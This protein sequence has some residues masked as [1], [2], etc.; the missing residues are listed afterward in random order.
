MFKNLLTKANCI[1]NIGVLKV[2]KYSPE[3]LLA[4]GIISVMSGTVLACK[5]TPKVEGIIENAKKTFDNIKYVT[6]NP[7]QYGDKYSEQD[8]KK[9]IAIVYVQTGV[10]LLKVYSKAIIATTFGIG[11]I[12]YSYKIIKGR[13]LASVAA[14]NLLDKAFTKYRNAVIDEFG[15]EKDEEFMYGKKT[16]VEKIVD[17]NGKEVGTK[18]RKVATQYSIY[19]RLF[20]E[21]N[22]SWSDNPEYNKMFLQSK[23]NYANDLLRTRGHLFLNEVYDMLGLERSSAGAVVGW[24][25]KQDET[26]DGYIDF[27]L[28]DF[29]LLHDGKNGEVRRAFINNYNPSI[30]L[31][32]NV[33]GVIYDLI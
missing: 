22:S 11:C 10:K 23:Q 21:F 14:Y 12:L 4:T 28:Y 19:S 5:A 15:A 26:S 24:L 16:I 1:K 9:D 18:E 27:K 13:Y 20:D 30:M 3:I 6:D 32:F 29:D 25:Y 7:E 8:R 17:E 33:D 31:D 2:K